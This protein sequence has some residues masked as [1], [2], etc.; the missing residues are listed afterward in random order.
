MHLERH[1][2]EQQRQPDHDLPLIQPE[3]NRGHVETKKVRAVF[4]KKRPVK[5]QKRDTRIPP[6]PRLVSVQFNEHDVCG[7]SDDTPKNPL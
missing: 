6:G 4:I 7:G 3:K 5:C 1:R 2:P